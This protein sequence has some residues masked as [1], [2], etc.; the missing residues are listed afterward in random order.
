VAAVLFCQCGSERVD[1]KVWNGTRAQLHCFTCGR[2]A[3]LDGFTLSEF[4]PAKLLTAAVVD[5]ARKHRKR[6][7][8]EVQRL[9]ERRKAPAR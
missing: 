4:D 5:Q 3:W 7:P 1:I 8:E 9:H 6:P 2:E